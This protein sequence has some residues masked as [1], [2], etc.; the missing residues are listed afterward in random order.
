MRSIK[1]IIAAFAIIAGL[2]V[3]PMLAASPAGAI[4]VYKGCAGNQD[5]E[6]CKSKN[7]DTVGTLVTNVISALLFVVGAISVIMIIVGGIRYTLSNGDA[8]QVKSAKDTILYA[9]IGLVVSLLSYSIVRF[10]INQF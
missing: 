3:A 4:N 7:T 9:V 6:V 1:N 8:S 5:T 2:V 10:V